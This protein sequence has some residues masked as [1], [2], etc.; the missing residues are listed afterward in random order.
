MQHSSSYKVLCLLFI[1][2]VCEN[3][4]KYI[5]ALFQIGDCV[6][7]YISSDMLDIAQALWVDAC[8]WH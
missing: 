5:K 7:C 8:G 4:T 1:D 2:A 3:T 6:N